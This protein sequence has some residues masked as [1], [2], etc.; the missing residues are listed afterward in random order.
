MNSS[1]G[2]TAFPWFPP[3][4]GAALRIAGNRRAGAA[5]GGV[6]GPGA[7]PRMGGE[8]SPGEET[9]LGRLHPAAQMG[10]METEEPGG[11]AG[12]ELCRGGGRVPRGDWDKRGAAQQAWEEGRAEAAEADGFVQ[13]LAACPLSR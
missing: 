3:R 11:A 4:P 8:A 9:S 10:R 7:P 13:G 12:I 2:P 5:R 1:L 6:W